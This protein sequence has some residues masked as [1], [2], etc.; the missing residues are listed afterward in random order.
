MKQLQRIVDRFLRRM[1]R[2]RRADDELTLFCIEHNVR[3]WRSHGL[4]AGVL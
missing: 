2:Y 3:T 1:E 4:G